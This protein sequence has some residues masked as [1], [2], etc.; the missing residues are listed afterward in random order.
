[1]NRRQEAA[2]DDESIRASLATI[3]ENLRDPT[4][5]VSRLSITE[6]SGKRR[7]LNNRYAEQDS[8]LEVLQ[9][10]RNLR[11]LKSRQMGITTIV[12]AFLVWRV[13][14]AGA[15]YDV[16][17]VTH[18][19]RA[20]RRVT[21]ALRQM[22]KSLPWPLAPEIIVDNAAEIRIRFAGHESSFC[23]TMAGGRD[24]GRSYTFRAVHFTE[25]G[26]YPTGSS[27]RANADTDV[28]GDLISS[29]LSTMPTAD[30]DP[31]RMVIEESTADGPRGIWYRRVCEAMES[32]GQIA[33]LFHPWWKFREYQKSAEGFV[34]DDEEK[35][36]LTD[37]PGMTVEN[38]AFRRYKLKVEGYGITRFRREFPT[39]WKE[40]FLVSGGMWFDTEK[41]NAALSKLTIKTPRTGWRVYHAPEKGRKYFAGFDAAGGVD[42]DSSVCV[43]VRDDLAVCAVWSS[44]TANPRRQAEIMAPRL[45]VYN[46][47]TLVE[48][49]NTYGRAVKKRLNALKVNLWHT[50]E[51]KD[52]ITDSR[53]KA[54]IMDFSRA[55]LEEDKLELNDALLIAEM[56]RIREQKDGNIAADAGFHDDHAVAHALALWAARRVYSRPVAQPPSEVD[57]QKNLLRTLGLRK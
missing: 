57:V 4:W 46:A 25:V 16:L 55:E 29:I 5:L 7:R 36:L 9:K 28:D 12:L 40:P 23:C 2:R 1:M 22:L 30:V 54:Q 15:T 34:P 21:R 13:L 41:L 43:I 50:D 32:E 37:N 3:R 26:F 35:K 49:G 19:H 45:H 33:F 20:I 17:I 8:V 52:F 27:A 53:T 24:Q 10:W 51:G 38:L 11:V 14:T 47:T 6:K 31:L 48:L 56:T 44:T 39:T 18:E 42:R